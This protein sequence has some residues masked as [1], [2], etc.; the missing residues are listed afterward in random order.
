MRQTAIV[1]ALIAAGY[2]V[3]AS[4]AP[5]SEAEAQALRDQ[6]KILTAR[7][8]ALEKQVAGQTAA[9]AALPQPSAPAAPATALAAAAPKDTTSIDWKGS[10]QFKQGDRLFKVKGRIQMDAG[11]VSRPPGSN[12]RG[13]GFVSEFRRIRLGGEGKL[14]AGFG[15]KLELELS[16][17]AVDLV[18]TFIT[19]ERDGLTLTLGNQNQFQSLDELTGDTSGSFM[20][21][22]AFT[23]A[24]AFERRLGLSAQYS[25]GPLLAQ[26]GLFTDDVGA[27]ANNADGPAGGDE[28]NSFGMDGRLVFAPRIGSTQLHFAG[29]AHWRNLK[30]VAEDGT[31]YR[32]R[33]YLHGTNSRLLATPELSVDQELH[34]GLELA[35]IRGP[36][37][38][39][40]EGHWLTAHR[41]GLPDVQFFGGYAEVGYFLTRGDSRGYTKGI[42]DRMKPHAPLGSG[43]PGAIQI[44]A[45]YDYLSLN[46]GVVIG[47]RQDA[48][49]GSIIWAPID[50]LR[51]NLNYGYLAYSQ[52]P[53][54]VAD[55]GVHTGGVRMELD[56]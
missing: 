14:G 52:M 20:E 15:Y 27:L 46:D 40:G 53:D 44:N 39:A 4:A 3:P 26:A 23:D 13:L 17:N 42:F 55:F 8:E 29:S 10:P 33:P 37:H 2:G 16:D 18:D 47:G 5:V 43:G 28:N 56:F 50:Y 32:Q 49:L 7:L 12:D 19:Y 31:R 48:F 11:Y 54:N 6:I 30:R 21:R 24:F 9:A 34:Y 38:F 36:L 45:R 51:V 22:A 41:P 25:H 1:V 35:A